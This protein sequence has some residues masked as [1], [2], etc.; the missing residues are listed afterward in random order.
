MFLISQNAAHTDRCMNCQCSHSG[1][2]LVYGLFVLLLIR[3]H[4]YQIK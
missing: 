2:S 4:V 3:K 1:M